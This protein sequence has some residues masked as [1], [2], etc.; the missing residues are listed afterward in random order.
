MQISYL[1]QEKMRGQ[2][3]G[4]SRSSPWDMSCPRKLFLDKRKSLLYFFFCSKH[5]SFI[6]ATVNYIYNTAPT[7][8]TTN[9]SCNGGRGVTKNLRAMQDCMRTS[10]KTDFCQK[11]KTS[12]GLKIKK[13]NFCGH[14]ISRPTL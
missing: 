8:T 6:A 4:G 2:I 10:R 13:K 3:E 11:S 12:A 5:L 9:I 1:Y 7:Y 14:D